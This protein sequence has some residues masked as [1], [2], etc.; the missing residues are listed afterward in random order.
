LPFAP[1]RARLATVSRLPFD[2]RDPAFIRAQQSR[3][4]WFFERYHRLHVEGLARVPTGRALVVGNHNGGIM[5][6]D[7]FGLMVAW[8]R[9]RG[10]DDAAYGLM[11]DMPFRIPLLGDAMA[12]FGAVPAHPGHA[13]ALLSRDAKVLVYPGGD[14]DAFRPYSKRHE[15]VFGERRGFVRVALRARA[16]IVPVVSVGAHEANYVVTDGRGIAKA[17]GLKRLRMEVMPI[18]IGLPWGIWLG[19]HFYLP[20]PVDIRIRVLDPIAWPE[21]SPEAADDDAIVRRCRD[22][23]VDHMQQAL[24]AMSREGGFG[25]RFF[26]RVPGARA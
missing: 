21:L 15:I 4:A 7:M 17:L 20:I 14:L 22:E 3:L 16:P 19:T 2:R 24:T 13:H 6:P 5:S 11:H 23:V 12:R 9:E 18:S 26:S 1:A 25:P 10:A 8:W